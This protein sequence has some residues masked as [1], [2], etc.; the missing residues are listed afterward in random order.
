MPYEIIIVDNRSAEADTIAYLPENLKAG[1]RPCAFLGQAVHYSAL[2]NFAV[3]E[4]KGTIIGLVN[5]D[6]EV[7][8]PDWLTEM[9][10][11]AAQKDVGCVGAKLYYPNDTSPACRRR[12]WA[13]VVWPVIRTSTF[14]ATI[15]ATS[16]ASR[17]CRICRP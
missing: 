15:P 5:N 7:I 16:F 17:Y 14:H 3:S 12:Y 13:L 2:N 1:Q 10:S 11:W 6:I 9:V 8:S 4:A